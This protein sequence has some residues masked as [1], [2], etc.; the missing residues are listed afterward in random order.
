[1]GELALDK[2]RISGDR[3]DN[4]K[5]GRVRKMALLSKMR[6]AI[7]SFSMEFN[8]RPEGLS[9]CIV[10]EKMDHRKANWVDI[11]GFHFIV[12]FVFYLLSTF[13]APRYMGRVCVCFEEFTAVGFSE[14]RTYASHVVDFI[15]VPV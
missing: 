5:R 6:Y 7:K 1:M 4:Y 13:S 8:G 15:G 2:V 10:T 14:K 9:V 11:F 12:I 3:C